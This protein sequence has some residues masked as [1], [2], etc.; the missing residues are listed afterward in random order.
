MT[1]NFQNLVKE[2][3]MQVQE[4]QRLPIKI[5]PK[6]LTPRHVTIKMA[7]FIK[8]ILKAASEK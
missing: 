6:R 5:N 3:I 7:K 4:I 1:E 8:T 2:N